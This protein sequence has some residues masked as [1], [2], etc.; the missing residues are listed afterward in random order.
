MKKYLVVSGFGSVFRSDSVISVR[1]GETRVAK[2]KE[3]KCGRR[4]REQMDVRMCGW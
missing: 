4:E 3:G 1:R 2:A